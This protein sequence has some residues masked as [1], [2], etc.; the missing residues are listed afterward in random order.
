MIGNMEAANKGYT[1][2]LEAN[3]ENLKLVDFRQKI[4]ELEK[5]MVSGNQ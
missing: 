1:K 3:P 4:D 5:K 2:L